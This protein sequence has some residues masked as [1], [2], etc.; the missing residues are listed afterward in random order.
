MCFGCL[1]LPV[2]HFFNV[3]QFDRLENGT[4]SVTQAPSLCSRNSLLDVLFFSQ[5]IS[6]YT[7]ALLILPLDLRKM[8]SLHSSF[9][10]RSIPFPFLELAKIKFLIYFPL[11]VLVLYI[12]IFLSAII[13]A[14]D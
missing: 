4:A 13:Y 11:H 6:D 8:E 7:S 14:R 10:L 3:T 5:N 12:G 2:V 9:A 1:L